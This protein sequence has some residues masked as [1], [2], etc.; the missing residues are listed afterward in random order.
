MVPLLVAE[1]MAALMVVFLHAGAA[2]SHCM[3]LDHML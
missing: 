1:P 3:G 2:E